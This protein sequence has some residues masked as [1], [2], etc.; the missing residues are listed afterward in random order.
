MNIRKRYAK[1]CLFLWVLGMCLTAHSLKAQSVIPVPLKMEQGTGSFL[2]SE[3]T[4]LYTNLQG[5][6]A[7]LLENCL[8]TLPIHLKKGKKKDT[9]NVLSLL[10][11]EKS[12]QLPTPESYT[13]SV[14]PERIQIQAT[15]GAGLFY[16]IQTLLQLSVSSD[17]G[18][19]TVSAVEVQDTPRF[20]YRGLMLDVSRHFFTK[21]FVKKQIDALAFY[22]INRL[23]LHLTDAAGW[24]IEIKKYPLLTEFAAWRTDA[25]W[26]KWWNGD[27]KYVR[28]DEPGA[29]GGYYTQDDIREIV[30][31]ARQHFITVI[32]E[33]E[34]PAHSE[35]VLSAYP[36]LSCAGEPYKNADFC[37]GNEETF[38][39]LEN[40]LTEVLEL[41]PS[42]YIHIGGDEAG[43]AAWKTC[44]KC[45]K[46]MKD[47]HLSHVDELQSYLIHRIEK[48]LN[49]RGRRLLGWD[50]ILK[51]GL[52]PNATVMSWRGEEG[53]IA[54]VTSG[55]RAV[56][57]PGSHCY[58]DSY[59]D[60]PYS[61][62][63]A[64]GGY[65]PLKKVY[66]YNPVAASLSAEQAKLVYGAQ[67]NLFTEYVPTP[68][69]VEYMLYPRTLAL[70]EVAWSAPERKSWPDFHAR[71]LKA[72]L[73]LQAKGY[74][75]FDLKNEIGSRPESTKTAA[76]LAL[77]KKVIYNAPYSLHYPAQGNTALTDGIRGDWTYGDGCWQGFIN[78]KRLDVTIDMEAETSIHSVTA[79][80][81]QVVG[82]EVFLPASVTISIS[83]DGINFTELKHQT[84]EVTKEDPIKFTDI[85]WEGNAQGRYVRYQ[86]Q[87]GK[88]FG[89]WVFTDEI[90]VK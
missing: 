73:D 28:F 45:Q 49:A 90:I 46:R 6:E 21:E 77:G 80:F 72:V 38:T 78:G 27:R 11:T 42:E 55:H 53:G 61:Q 81:M 58:L 57:T 83:D 60:A 13:L 43:M 2:L 17:T 18:V 40:V 32:P 54:A 88:E 5:G 14:T 89:G 23:H 48:F 16:G 85:S 25:N 39:F 7:Q 62:P 82:A 10:I 59:Q 12:G 36:Q 34:M 31:Y 3:K 86:A 74:H 70:A 56:M 1:V 87:A 75:P 52:A 76:H 15:S 24:R 8:Q 9:Q 67:V 64:I 47:E 79:A 41:F 20:A 84:F 51:G 69:H 33:I 44:P 30:E 66:A 22:K 37:V 50:E 35:E 19:I 26:K 68:E 63:E 4:K 65:L 29:S 71:A